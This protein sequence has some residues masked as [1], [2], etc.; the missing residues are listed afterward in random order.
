[1]SPSLQRL[2][3]WASCLAQLMVVL[4]ISVVNVALPSIQ[5]DLDD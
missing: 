3:L 4:D 2:G 1:M 5:T